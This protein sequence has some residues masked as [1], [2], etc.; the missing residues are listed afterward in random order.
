MMLKGNTFLIRALSY[1][2]DLLLLDVLNSYVPYEDGRQDRKDTDK[3]KN[4]DE[5]ICVKLVSLRPGR[6]RILS[7]VDTCK[8]AYLRILLDLMRLYLCDIYTVVVA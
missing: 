6:G 4:K 8:V 3:D 5:T 1:I 2:I 7:V